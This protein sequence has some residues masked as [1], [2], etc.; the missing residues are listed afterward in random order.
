MRKK[1]RTQ[2]HSSLGHYGFGN[3]AAVFN[4]RPKP[5]FE[6]VKTIYGDEMERYSLERSTALSFHQ[7]IPKIELDNIRNGIRMA[8]KKTRKKEFLK[9][10]LF[11]TLIAIA[12][13]FCYNL[14]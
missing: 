2:L 13:V 12:I 3:T 5:I 1:N 9:R 11:L 7:D 6:K 10:G 4:R 8:I 14:L